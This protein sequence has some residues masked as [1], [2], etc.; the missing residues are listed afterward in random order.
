MHCLVVLLS[1]YTAMHTS[2]HFRCLPITPF[3]T[4]LFTHVFP[5]IRTLGRHSNRRGGN[6][7]GKVRGVGERFGLGAHKVI[8]HEVQFLKEK[9]KYIPKNIMQASE[10]RPRP[11]GG[12]EG[13]RSGKTAGDC[14]SDAEVLIII[15]LQKMNLF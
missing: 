2:Q 4:I 13:G 6:C 14:E 7:V 1:L 15:I 9:R 12:D 11:V 8:S 3:K 5:F 10:S